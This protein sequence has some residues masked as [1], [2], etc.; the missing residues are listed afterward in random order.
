MMMMMMIRDDG[1]GE[2]G[3]PSVSQAY[4]SPRQGP[5]LPQ[6]WILKHEI[7]RFGV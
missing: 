4:P 7:T 1:D 2:H 5:T 6:I 3:S